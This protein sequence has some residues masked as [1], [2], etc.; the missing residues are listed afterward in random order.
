MPDDFTCQGETAA[1][2]WLIRLPFKHQAMHPDA[3]YFANLLC[4]TPGNFRV[5]PLKL[6]IFMPFFKFILQWSG[7]GEASQG[8]WSPGHAI[9]VL[10]NTLLN[11]DRLIGCLRS[12]DIE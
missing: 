5:L 2:Q 1:N 12:H 6:S 11:S 8:N 10:Y 3:P 9:P 4:L 7:S